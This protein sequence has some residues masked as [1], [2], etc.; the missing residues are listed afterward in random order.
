MVKAPKTDLEN[1][2]LRMKRLRLAMGYEEQKDWAKAVEI[3]KQRWNQ[4][5]R[6]KVPLSGAVTDILVGRIPGLTADWCRYGRTGG[7]TVDMARLLE[8]S[9]PLPLEPIPADSS[10]DVNT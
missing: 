4:I 8:G 5:E 3:S 7:L 1:V 10:E 6:G 2:G 9:P